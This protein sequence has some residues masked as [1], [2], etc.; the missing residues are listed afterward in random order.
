M[1]NFSKFNF[2]GDI[3]YKMEEP[4]KRTI[5][6]TKNAPDGLG[7]FNQAILVN[8]TMYISG[9]LGLIPETSEFVEGGVTEQAFQVLIQ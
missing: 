8:Q 9:Q 7:P 1:R 4:I 2:S 5:I 3:F 6:Q